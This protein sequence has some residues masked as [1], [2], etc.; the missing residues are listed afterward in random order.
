MRE[1]AGW[2]CTVLA[3]GKDI[4][5]EQLD[6]GGR[7]WLAVGPSGK[8]TGGLE[9]AL[10]AAAGTQAD[11]RW[12]GAV[13]EAIRR[14]IVVGERRSQLLVKRGTGLWFHATFASNRESINR[15]GLDWRYMSGPG[16]AGSVT[17]EWPG[18]F[19]CDS[20]EA[21]EFFAMIGSH[22]GLVDIWETELEGQW[23]E[24]AP[25]SDGGGG[26]DWM[27]CPEPIGRKRIRLA[28]RDIAGS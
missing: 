12:I 20:L 5:I 10:G 4:Q 11:A 22:R 23:L 15:H 21:A 1:R 17:A 6:D 7:E 9:C 18:I 24:G 13:A 16:I 2:N 27:I 19:L 26:E 8:C 14:E 25:A 28:K 3:P